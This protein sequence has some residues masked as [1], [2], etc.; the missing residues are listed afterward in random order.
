MPRSI[1]TSST[2]PSRGNGLVSSPPLHRRHFDY[3]YANPDT[4]PRQHHQ[5]RQGQSRHNF[6]VDVTPN[7]KILRFDLHTGYARANA[8]ASSSRRAHALRR[9]LHPNLGHG[10]SNP[11][12][13][14][15]K[16]YIERESINFR[17]A[18]IRRSAPR[19]PRRHARTHHRTLVGRE[20][21]GKRRCSAA[22]ADSRRGAAAP[23]HNAK[24]WS[25]ASCRGRPFTTT[26]ARTFPVSA[27]DVTLS[28]T[29]RPTALVTPGSS[30]QPSSPSSSSGNN[31]KSGRVERR[32]L[33]CRKTS[34]G[35][36][37]GRR[38][39]Q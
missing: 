22:H 9:G 26:T 25:T 16:T 14:F 13:P 30:D 36:L 19:R 17:K 39:L 34:D 27:G 8:S 35:L 11:F 3:N 4:P 21:S 23:R 20:D 31:Q 12:F 37:R 33:F 5:R 29:A 38:P 1:R 15:F 6:G 24:F 7:D 2:L 10:Q 28:A 18:P 32:A